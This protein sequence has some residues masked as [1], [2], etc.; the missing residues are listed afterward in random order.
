MAE[1]QAFAPDEAAAPG[2]E[3]R[4]RDEGCVFPVDV[5]SEAEAAAYRRRLEELER[6]AA[7]SKLGNKTQL[8]YPHV[9]FGFADEIV[10]HPRILDV[11]ESF[12]GPDILVWGGTFFVKE[13]HTASFVSWHQDLRY[14]GLDDEDGQ[15]SAWLALGPVTRENGCMRIVPGSH[16]GGL[17]AHR[18]TFDDQNFL[19]R[20]QEVDAE[21]DEGEVVHVELRA[22]QASFHHGRL[23]HGSGPNGSDERR[24]GFAI[25]YIAPHVH[26]TVAKEDFA[27]LVRGEDRYGHFEQVPPPQADLAPEALAW[28]A[29]ILAAQNEVLYD[30]A[31][32]AS[33]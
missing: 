26:Q 2:L 20:G 10:R 31:P 7:G 25:N 6:R 18:D 17:L 16:K 29:R 21:I 3:D 5:L 19:T 14:W 9:I 11:V 13:P 12:L 23:L 24:I 1:T 28:H 15:V 33:T 22:G 30:G 32:L 8:N 27:M 4:Y